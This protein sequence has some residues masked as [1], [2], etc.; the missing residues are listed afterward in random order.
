M[1]ILSELSDIRSDLIRMER[2]LSDLIETQDG[3]GFEKNIRSKFGSGMDNGMS[4]S[5]S[6]PI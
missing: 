1:A 2:V 5:E 6:D 3:Y 4:Q